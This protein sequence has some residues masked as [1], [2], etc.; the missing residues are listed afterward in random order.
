MSGAPAL[1]GAL[2][3]LGV[4][5]VAAAVFV[6]LGRWQLA[7]AELNRAE[8]ERF[9]AGAELPALTLAQ[10]ADDPRAARYRRLELAG[11]YVP[12]RHVLLDNMMRAGHAG[13]EVLTPFEPADGSGLLLVNRGW[14]PAGVDR[15]ELP[16]VALT[17]PVS[18][19]SGRLDAFPRAVLDLGNA[20]AA[21]DADRVVLSY[22]SAAELAALFD[23]TIAPYQLRLDPERPNGFARD[24]RPDSDRPARN[25]GYAVQWFAFAAVAAGGAVI[26]GVRARRRIM[27]GEIS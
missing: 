23:R 2:V 11:R 10:V 17:D 9:S 24:W 16:D 8:L 27:R 5:L 19:V 1:R 22:P 18:D 7:R 4:L 14:I 21:A 26:V 12:S 20:D 3:P 15:R 13:Y 25:V 6:S